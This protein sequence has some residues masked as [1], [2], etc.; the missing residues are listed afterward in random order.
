MSAT[1]PKNI[2]ARYVFEKTKYLIGCMFFLYKLYDLYIK[3][4]P[5]KIYGDM[6]NPTKL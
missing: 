6:P 5:K 3:F 2:T 4:D 1:I